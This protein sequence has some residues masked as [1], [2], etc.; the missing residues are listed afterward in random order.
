LTQNYCG[1]LDS[2]GAPITTNPCIVPGKAPFS[3]LAP[4]GTELPGTPKIK[5]SAGAR[6][7]FPV[8]GWEGHVAGDIVYQSYVWPQLR[9]LDR[10]ILGQQ[11]AYAL[12]NLFLGVEKNG[13]SIE[14]LVKNAFDR[15]ASLYRFANCGTVDCGPV[16]TYEI[17]SPPRLIGV[18]VGQ[19]F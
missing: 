18:Q 11:P 19:R 9:V 17:V 16:A 2:S 1:V 6:Y 5:T 15:R 10:S 3:P 12:T 14:L 7:V 8:M 4:E 13:L